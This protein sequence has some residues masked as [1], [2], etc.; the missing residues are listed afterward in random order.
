MTMN[1]GNQLI[2]NY[3]DLKVLAEYG[4]LSLFFKRL[5]DCI[6]ANHLCYLNYLNYRVARY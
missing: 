5:K 4:V 6:Y 1:Y 3:M 2:I